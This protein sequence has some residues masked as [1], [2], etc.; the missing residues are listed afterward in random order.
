M[1]PS[2]TY[3]ES[4]QRKPLGV[5]SARMWARVKRKKSDV[6]DVQEKYALRLPFEG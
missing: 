3:A 2:P 5:L 6:R 4:P 1:Y